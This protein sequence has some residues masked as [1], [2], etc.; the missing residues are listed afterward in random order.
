VIYSLLHDVISTD[1]LQTF[2]N[3]ISRTVL[4]AVNLTI[5]SVDV[6]HCVF[7]LRQLNLFI[8]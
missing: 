2:F 1:L 7:N 6:Q 5:F 3:M 8:G 4:P